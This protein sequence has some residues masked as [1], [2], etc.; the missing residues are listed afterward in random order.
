[1]RSII[2]VFKLLTFSFLCLFALLGQGIFQFLFKNS[3]LYFFFATLF[4]RASLFIFRIKVSVKSAQS[5]KDNIIYLGN[6]LSYIDIPVLS[7]FIQGVFIAK[8][9]VRQWPVFGAL[10]KVGGT[11]FIDRNRGAALNAIKS[12]NEALEAKHPLIIFPEG[13]S[14]NGAQVLPF[15]SSLFELFLNQSLKEK[16]IIQ[17]FT[18]KIIETN[19]APIKNITDH[20]FYAWHG[21]MTL[22]PHLWRLATSKGAKIQLEFHETLAA[23][24]FDDRKAFAK[25]CYNDVAKGLEKQ[26]E[27]P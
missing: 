17:P 19:G 2:A 21:N 9:S 26:T 15:K 3:P 16:L 23:K 8:A 11:V 25:A 20:D 24:D 14:T 18:I 27:H 13:T 12:I 10:A 22:P 1:M 7:A 5:G 6:H 4:G